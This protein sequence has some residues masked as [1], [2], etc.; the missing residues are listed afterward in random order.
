MSDHPYVDTHGAVSLGKPKGQ[1]DQGRPKD[2]KAAQGPQAPAGGAPQGP[3]GP[4]LDA[5]LIVDVTTQTFDDAV[6][7]SRTVPVVLV[8]WSARTLES[9]QLVHTLEQLA[10]EYGGRFQLAKVDADANVEISQALQAQAVPTAV[11]IV[12]GHPLPLFQGTPATDQVRGVLDQVLQAAA[13]IGV[14]G[15]IAVTPAEKAPPEG[16]D[17]A[18]ARAAQRDGDLDRAVELWERVVRNHPQDAT[19][20]GELGRARLAQRL[21]RESRGADPTDPFARA[22]GLFAAGEVGR[23]FDVLLDVLGDPSHPDRKERARA[24]LLEFFAQQGETPD[25]RAARRRMS[26]LLLI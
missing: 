19:A 16:P 10:R 23:S 18:E 13:R 3:Q 2:R 24:R 15:T 1:G 5:P 4:Q 11:A 6:S 7:T 20:P 14:S 21:A 12:G 26:T 25:V 8:L 17:Y 9:S 22:D